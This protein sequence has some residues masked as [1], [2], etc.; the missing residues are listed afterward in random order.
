[1]IVNARTRRRNKLPHRIALRWALNA[2]GLRRNRAARGRVA[3]VFNV[4]DGIG[5]A[6][7]LRINEI[8]I[9]VRRR[10]NELVPN[11]RRYPLLPAA[12]LPWRW[13]Y[14]LHADRTGVIARRRRYFAR[15]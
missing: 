13:K 10:D 9:R 4:I 15:T 11:W 1:M 14:R 2:K 7:G 5:A 8:H 12:D 3:E 6:A